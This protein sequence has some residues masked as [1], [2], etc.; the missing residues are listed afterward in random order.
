MFKTIGSTFCVGGGTSPSPWACGHA[1]CSYSP[2]CPP[3]ESSSSTPAMYHYPIMPFIFP[4]CMIVNNCRLTVSANFMKMILN[5]A[6]DQLF[7]TKSYSLGGSF[8]FS[9]ALISLYTIFNTF[10]C[11]TGVGK[12]FKSGGRQQYVTHTKTCT[13]F[14]PYIF[15]P[16]LLSKLSVKS[17]I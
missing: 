17:K 11:T 10:S 3:N 15:T 14:S 6:E 13:N 1:V 4:H 9:L 12:W 7:Q 16:D 8:F 5:A 2:V